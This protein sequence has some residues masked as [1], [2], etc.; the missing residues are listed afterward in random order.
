[1]ITK[2]RINLPIDWGT[3]AE[4][5]KHYVGRFPDNKKELIEFARLIKR[6]IESQVDFEVIGKCAA[7]EFK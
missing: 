7:E 1:M 2:L 6:G 4:E 3:N 5:F